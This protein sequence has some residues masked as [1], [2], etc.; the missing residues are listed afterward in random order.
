MKRLH[1]RVSS[2]EAG[3]TLGR[4]LQVID[5]HVREL[6]ATRSQGPRRTFP[7]PVLDPANL[8]TPALLTLDGRM[9]YYNHCYCDYYNCSHYTI[10]ILI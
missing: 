4:V 9:D 7:W 1:D 8:G 10:A 5:Q 3:W 2:A 6:A